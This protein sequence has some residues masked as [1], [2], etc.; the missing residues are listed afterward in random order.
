MQLTRYSRA[1]IV[2]AALACFSGA[3]A[4]APITARSAGN[5][6]FAVN[7][8]TLPEPLS[9]Q[10]VAVIAP[11]RDPFASAPDA[12]APPLQMT[13][14]VPRIP[15]T[16]GG[17]PSNLTGMIPLI[18]GS[19][20]LVSRAETTR[21]SA[22]VTGAHPYAL[23]V[24]NNETILKAIGDTI[25]GSRIT[26]ITMDGVRLEGGNLRRVTSSLIQAL[27]N[28]IRPAARAAPASVN[29]PTSTPSPSPS[30]TGSP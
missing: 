26:G 29:A 11:H 20:N 25:D 19:P 22:V 18:P 12:D 3:F 6:P 14:L 9:V 13:S 28:L 5:S 8:R 21:V 4:L 27:P 30:A 17:L 10:A 16:I 24:E 2:A 23:V 7:D 1:A 15:A